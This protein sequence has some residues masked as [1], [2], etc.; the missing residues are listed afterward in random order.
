MN[1]RKTNKIMIGLAILS[2]LVM[3][4]I[5]VLQLFK[6]EEPSQSIVGNDNIQ[7]N[8][9]GD[10]N[11]GIGKIENSTVNI[12]VG[13]IDS[14]IRS[15]EFGITL[16]SFSEQGI[17][18]EEGTSVGLANVVGLFSDEKTR[19]R[20]ITDYK[21]SIS[22]LESG[23]QRINLIYNPESPDQIIGKR[24]DFLK[25]MDILV[26]NYSEFLNTIRLN[27]DQNRPIILN[28]DVFLNGIKVISISKEVPASTICN[29]QASMN[30]MEYFN[31]I[32]NEYKKNVNNQNF[33]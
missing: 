18:T 16:D 14:I 2:I 22:K 23:R 7:I 26:M 31:D 15:L 33:R 28:F 12:N 11:I 24:I 9:E 13:K 5:G 30:I 21:Y 17:A 20:F 25:N 29:G 19:Y 6:Q 3:I 4:I 10:K 1:T 8:Q 32:D 27:I